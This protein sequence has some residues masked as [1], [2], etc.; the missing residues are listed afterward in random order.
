MISCKNETEPNATRNSGIEVQQAEKD[1]NEITLLVKNV[2]KWLNI[3]DGPSGFSPVTKDSLIVGYDH[4]DQKLYEKELSKSGLFAKEFVDN[5]ARIFN[6]Q[7]E[8]LRNGKA[9]WQEGD[10][11][12]FGGSDVNAWCRCQDQPTDDFDKINVVIEKMISNTADLYWNWTGFGED[13][14]NEHYHIKVVKEN[15]RW[16]IAWMEGWDYEENVKLNY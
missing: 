8:L 9:E 3:A 4:A 15:G 16:K 13:W 10:M 6:K 14:E 2:Y 11:P 7:D 5:T 12:P 1:R